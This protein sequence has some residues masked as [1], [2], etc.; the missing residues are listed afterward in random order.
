MA[1]QALVKVRKEIPSIKLLLIGSPS[2][3]GYTRKLRN[4][5]QALRLQDFVEILSWQPLE[6]VPTYIQ[7]SNVG[8]VPHRRNPHTDSTIPHKLFQYML[9]GKPVIVSNCLPLE[10]LVLETK[11]GLV[12]EAGNSADLALQIKELYFNK[13]LRSECGSAGREAVFK[14]Y[15]WREEAKKLISM[16]D[17]LSRHKEEATQILK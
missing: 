15:N 10:R 14:R 6:K 7:L 3:E 11:S 5:I 9:M 17:N 13:S 16:Y 2:D 8:L 12:F 1:V 4:L